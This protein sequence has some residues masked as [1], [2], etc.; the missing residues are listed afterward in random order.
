LRRHLAWYSIMGVRRSLAAH[1]E[2]RH[3]HEYP[4]L[5]AD[6]TAGNYTGQGPTT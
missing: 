1:E 6:T 5:S 3:L 2:A 4:D